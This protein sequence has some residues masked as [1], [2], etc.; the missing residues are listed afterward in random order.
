MNYGKIEKEAVTL[1]N[2]NDPEALPIILKPFPAKKV[3]ENSYYETY[4]KKTEN[5]IEQI[6]KLEKREE[7]EE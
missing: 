6:W 2:K 3:A 5:G 4:W 1:L 7:K